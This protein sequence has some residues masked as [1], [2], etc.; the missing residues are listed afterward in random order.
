MLAFNA[1]RRVSEALMSAHRAPRWTADELAELRRVFPVGGTKAA[2]ELL[3]GRSWYSI[4]VKAS[5][6]G[7]KMASPNWG[8]RGMTVA[9]D[10]LEEA[11]RLR[12]AEGWGFGRIG[13]HLGR[14]EA[15]V[16]N[17]VLIALCRRKGYT[18]AERHPNGRMTEAGIERLRLA[19][20]KGLKGV[21]IQLRLGVSAATVAEQRRRYNAELKARGKALLP[22][23]GNGASYSGVK[24]SKERRH[25]AERLFLLGYGTL[26]VSQGSGVSKTVCTRIRNKL[27]R[28]LKRKGECLPGCDIDGKRRTMKD[29]VRCIPIDSMREL[30]R[31]LKAGE[32]SVAEAGK[33]ARVGS[34]TAY[35]VFHALKAEVEAAGGEMPVFDW[36]SQPRKR[37]EARI[38]ALPQGRWAFDRYRALLR[39]TTPERAAKTVLAE[40][41]KRV[42][43]R[44]AI[45][46]AELAVAASAMTDA[47]SAATDEW[48]REQASLATETVVSFEEQLAKVSAGKA[49]VVPVFR[50]HRADPDFTLGGIATGAL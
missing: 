37:N 22:P 42:A 10:E 45:V 29:H 49:T 1:H 30:R 20:K 14:A 39:E 5:K 47:L 38:R 25:E 50:P 41:E 8:G 43:E 24:V 7:L 3:P 32:C 12:E 44:N 18:P 48:R 21:D 23:P 46:A 27:I 6:L 16:T 19:L 9:G 15:S 31:L 13:A 28:R 4:Q 34:C 40:H 2:L 26:K 17:A 36:R 33:R 35:R 11:I